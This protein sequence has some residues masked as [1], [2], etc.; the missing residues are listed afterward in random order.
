MSLTSQESWNQISVTKCLAFPARH[1]LNLAA[2]PLLSIQKSLTWL[3]IKHMI[4]S[5]WQR[6]LVTH[7][8]GGMPLLLHQ[9]N[10]F[11]V[12]VPGTRGGVGGW[13]F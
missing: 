10:H 1:S 2:A 9:L 8:L 3:Q 12:A 7:P 5:S 4:L 11:Y 6:R 13:G